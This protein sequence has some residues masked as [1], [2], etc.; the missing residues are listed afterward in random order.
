MRRP[1][2]PPPWP[3]VVERIANSGALPRLMSVFPELRESQPYRHW[4]ELRHRQPPDKVETI[5]EWWFLTKLSRASGMR[6]LPLKDLDGGKFRYNLP[7]EVLR[8]LDF[9]ASYLRG[10]IA[11]NEQ[12]TN[13]A[14]REQYLVGSLME[15][16][17][18]SSQLEGASTSKRVAKEMIQS[19][20]QPRDRSERMI[21]NNYYAMERVSQL[22]DEPLT[23]EV[24]CELHRL[25]TEGT[26]D[27]PDCA[28]RFQLVSEERVG[29]F[30]DQGQLLH[31]PPP[32]EEIE[33]R[34]AQLCAFANEESS[35]YYLPGVLRALAIHFMVGYIHP[36]EDGNG[37]TARI[38]FYW[39]MLNKGYWLTEFISVSS[40][41]NAAKVQYGRSF[42]YTETDEGD[43][44]YFFI[45]HL[46]ILHRCIDQLNSYLA[47]KAEEMSEVRNLLARE[48]ENFNARQIAVI[49]NAL[50]NSTF[51]YS[52]QSHMRAHRIAMETA[53]KDLV[54]L[55]E[56]SLLVRQRSG[57]KFI[58]RPVADLAER[59]RDGG[60]RIG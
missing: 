44:T 17:I 57:K 2:A 5:E 6:D 18:T 39:S 60:A 23:V 34:M 22:R 24:I 20:R 8:E 46:S 14:T 42:L 49:R 29:V 4:D 3:E 58:Y 38:L 15:E 13:P 9:G 51:P 16:A 54:E 10:R 30:D 12:V 28:G 31:E 7:D 40:L 41:L 26:L 32:A 47:R 33:S 21:L 45:Y 56:A 1:M 25:V 59:L 52:V 11:V 53:R 27:N 48:E 35:K 50:R 43:L 36:F 55:E 37:R 19:G